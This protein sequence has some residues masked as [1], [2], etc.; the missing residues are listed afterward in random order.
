MI[1][2]PVRLFV[3]FLHELGHALG[4][5]LTGGSVDAIQI[6][7]DGSGW[8]RTGGG[9]RA[10]TIMGGY[11]GSALFGNS[12]LYLSTRSKS[13]T[14]FTLT[15]LAV[16][17]IFTGFIWFNSLYTSGILIIFAIVLY[18]LAW[19]TS[20]SRAILMFLGLVSILYIIQDF[21]VGPRSD[22]E[23]YANELRIFPPQVWMYI[24]LGI[25]IIL[26]YLNL[27]LLFGKSKRL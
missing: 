8:T 2:Y 22:L 26:F 3:T 14:R 24:W 1:L 12:M 5:V 7:S 16:A 13:I 23:A 20:A 11:F 19:K 15:T 6:N 25:V 18:I 21:N 10:V 17:M 27:K 4:A 9:N